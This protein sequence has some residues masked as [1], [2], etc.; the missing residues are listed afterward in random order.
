MNE[1]I[2]IRLPF[3]IHC[4]ASSH[5]LGAV[6]YQKQGKQT[7]VISYA[8]RTLS[9]AERNYHLHSGKLEFLAL[10]W[11]VTE[12]FSEYLLNGSP[13]EV[14]TDNNPLTLCLNHSEIE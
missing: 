7:R 5:G 2:I 3:I 10:R 14:V 8:S 9:P 6:L 13:F 11:S 1:H 12:K 4:D